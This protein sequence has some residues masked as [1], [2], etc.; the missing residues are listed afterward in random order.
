MKRILAG[1]L[2]LVLV[3]SFFS[4]SVAT[5]PPAFAAT[6]WSS[7]VPISNVGEDAFN[8]KVAV[9]A[10]G[11]IVVVWRANV[12]GTYT[13]QASTS[14]DQGASW[15]SPVTLSTVGVRSFS[16]DIAVDSSGNFG[17]VWEEDSTTDVIKFS[18]SSDG[19]TWTPG[20]DVSDTTDAQSPQIVVDGSD[21]FT[22]VYQQATTPTTVKAATGD[23]AGVPA[24]WSTR[25]V[26]NPVNAASAPKI[27]ADGSAIG[28]V[29]VVWGRKMTRPTKRFGKRQALMAP[30]RAQPV[31]TP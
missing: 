7:G 27:A 26:S 12:S 24:S 29:M 31:S 17:V 8:Q 19:L 10:A 25:T 23:V 2:F 16:A 9:N 14:D 1:S 15:S 13:I 18:S 30:G 4:A 20:P 6:S 3:A 11:K 28:V 21:Y 5:V 22:V